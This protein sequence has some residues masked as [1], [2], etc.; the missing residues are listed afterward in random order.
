MHGGPTTINQA[1]GTSM[2]SQKTIRYEGEVTNTTYGWKFIWS[3]NDTNSLK[4]NDN[5][6]GFDFDA[7]LNGASSTAVIAGAEMT[8]C[9]PII[10]DCFNDQQCPQNASSTG[11]NGASLFIND[12]SIGSTAWTN[13][14]NAQLS[15][16][17]YAKATVSTGQTSNYLKATAFNFALPASALIQGIVVEWEK[18]MTVLPPPP[19]GMPTMDGIPADNA[20]R[21]VKDAAVAGD[22]KSKP[23]GWS[24]GDT[25]IS[26]GSPSD[27]WGLSW[28]PADM[29]SAP[30]VINNPNFGAVISIKKIVGS[31]S[32][33]APAQIDSVRMTVYYT[34]PLG[35]SL[36]DAAIGYITSLFK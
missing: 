36:Y 5:S 23:D 26:Y 22:D 24:T 15:D 29:N 19:P 35:G 18:S 30:G 11:S 3:G 9:V 31:A 1:L 14:S 17:I 32:S 21:L 12:A 28:T 34:T 8:F 13:P 25:S 33:V 2:A 6:F 20:V 7:K 27:V 10:I 16:N 4:A